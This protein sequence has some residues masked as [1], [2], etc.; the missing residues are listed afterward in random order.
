MG[1]SVKAPSIWQRIVFVVVAVAMLGMSGTMAWATVNEYQQRALIPCGVSI[2]GQTLDGMTAQEAGR[3]I[4]QTVSDPLSRPVT[5]STPAGTK[6]FEPGD[7]IS[8]DVESMLDQAYQAKTQGTFPE[9]LAC[10]LGES[11]ETTLAVRYN[12]DKAGIEAWVDELRATID[13]PSQN[14]YS[15]VVGAKLKVTPEVY[16]RQ[17]NRP[18]AIERIAN[19]VESETRAVTLPV[20]KITP[21][22]RVADMGKTIIVKKSTRT[23]TLY[24]KDKVERVWNVAVGQPQYPTPEGKWE[25]IQKRFMPTWMNPGS[26]WAKTMPASIPPGP[27]NP[28]GLRALNLN[29]PGIRIHGTSNIGSIGTAASHGC[30]R[31]ANSQVVELYPL[32][33]VGTPVYVVP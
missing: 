3:I 8:V 28:L 11:V 1:G 33:E 19:A 18:L 2:N 10:A 13:E 20:K 23:L 15:E 32:V 17:V 27:T 6:S 12:V 30:I 4:E 31:M 5:V 25:I 21:K 29:A 14:A 9:R 24:N 22:V 16:G 26:A 7:I